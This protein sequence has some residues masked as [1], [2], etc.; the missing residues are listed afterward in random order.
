MG[1]SPVGDWSSSDYSVP[2]S[3]P[4]TTRK[5]PLKIRR[6]MPRKHKISSSGE[7]ASPSS[8]MASSEALA[9][10]SGTTSSMTE[11]VVKK[12]VADIALPEEYNWVLPSSTQSANNPSAGYL[13]VYAS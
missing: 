1:G 5:L 11:E 6:K 9:V 2:S 3:P 7:V 12:L 4:Y 8:A 10:I 13:T